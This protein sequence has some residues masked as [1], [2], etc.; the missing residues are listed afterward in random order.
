MMKLILLFSLV[1]SA[2]L[3]NVHSFIPCV[4]QAGLATLGKV[5]SFVRGGDYDGVFELKK[6][7]Q[8]VGYLPYSEVSGKV[9][10]STLFLCSTYGVDEF[11]LSGAALNLKNWMPRNHQSVL[12]KGVQH[13][14]LDGNMVLT[15]VNNSEVKVDFAFD[16]RTSADSRLN[17]RIID[18]AILSL[19]AQPAF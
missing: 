5:S 1:G 4:A 14:S 2:A 15:R 7:R 19:K 3:A 12:L 13:S 17:E 8:V 6:A 10:F 16:F 18:K 9:V 11:Q